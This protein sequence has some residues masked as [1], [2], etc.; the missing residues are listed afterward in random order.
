MPKKFAVPTKTSLILYGRHAVIAALNNSE[1]KIIKLL[2][3]AE[4][5]P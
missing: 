4:N 3:T 5:A 1:R 2:C